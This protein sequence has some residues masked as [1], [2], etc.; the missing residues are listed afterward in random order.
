MEEKHSMHNQH[1]QHRDPAHAGH[2]VHTEND[3]SAVPDTQ[4]GHGA[5]HSGQMDHTEHKGHG[6]HG[7]GHGGHGVDHTGHEQMFRKRFWAN[8]VL[9]IPV[10]L[11]S[12]MLQEW[13]GFS[14]PEFPGSRWVGPAFAVAIFIYGGL[15]F[16][17][18]MVPEFP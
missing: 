15:P 11:F 16:I 8:L 12:P 7:S 6:G 5:M 2:G 4:A 10:L 3:R 18:M 14:M 13:L 9:T 1:N 17:Q